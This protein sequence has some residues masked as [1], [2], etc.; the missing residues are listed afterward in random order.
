[1][2]RYI[3]LAVCL[4]CADISLSDEIDRPPRF[5]DERPGEDGG[6]YVCRSLKNWIPSIQYQYDLAIKL[7]DCLGDRWDSVDLSRCDSQLPDGVRFNSQTR[8]FEFRLTESQ[9]TILCKINRAWVKALEKNDK[10]YGSKN[11]AIISLLKSDPA[12]Y[13]NLEKLAISM[14]DR[15]MPDGEATPQA[16]PGSYYSNDPGFKFEGFSERPSLQTLYELELAEEACSSLA[17]NGRFADFGKC[18]GGPEETHKKLKRDRFARST[19]LYPKTSS[20]M[21]PPPVDIFSVSGSLGFPAFMRAAQMMSGRD[22]ALDDY[23]SKTIADLERK[24]KETYESG[25]T[26]PGNTLESLIRDEYD[27]R[28]RN[29]KNAAGQEDC[30]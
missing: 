28:I 7:N 17:E 15:N 3:L 19:V 10:L 6:V 30:F 8:K 13:N 4:S 20:Q 9:K 25:K 11:E 16:Y 18:T 1:M 21:M 2:H 5:R 27:E 14:F 23:V 29:C 12:G 22:K 26:V 24:K